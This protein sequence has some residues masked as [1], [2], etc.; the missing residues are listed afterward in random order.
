[1]KIYLLERSGTW[2]GAPGHPSDDNWTFVRAYKTA[3]KA[4][5]AITPEMQASEWDHYRVRPVKV[6]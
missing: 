4:R 6:R 1:M 5:A 2:F 3:K